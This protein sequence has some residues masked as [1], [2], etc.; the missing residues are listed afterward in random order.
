MR[1]KIIGKVYFSD[2]GF[3]TDPLNK[4]AGEIIADA[5]DE[6]LRD[7]SCDVDVCLS[8]VMSWAKGVHHTTLDIDLPLGVDDEHP[9]RLRVR[10]D[11][12][13]QEAIDHAEE[14]ADKGDGSAQRLHRLAGT[15]RTLAKRAD[16]CA[17]RLDVSG[18]N[19][20]GE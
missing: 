6:Q 5:I 1:P 14:W 3:A 13:V 15:L 20:E 10:L 11:S 4:L 16:R 7:G 19:R 9:V 18:E 8:G 17:E 12:V 2:W